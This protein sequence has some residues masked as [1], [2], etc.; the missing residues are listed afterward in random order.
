MLLFLLILIA[1]NNSIFATR[2]M[3]HKFIPA[4]DRNFTVYE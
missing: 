3:F 4:N 1:I 2:F